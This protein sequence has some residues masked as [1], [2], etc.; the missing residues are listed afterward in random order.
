MKEWR[1]ATLAG[2]GASERGV[3]MKRYG[4]GALLSSLAG[5]LSLVVLLCAPAAPATATGAAAT[6]AHAAPLNPRFVL[7]QTTGLDLLPGGAGHGRGQRPAPHPLVA[8]GTS[9]LPASLGYASSFD[10]RT[11]GKVSPVRNQGA[12]GTCWSF[13][14][15]GSLESSFLPAQP[16]DFAEDHLVLT[17]GFDT[18]AT[19]TEKYNHGGNLWYSTAYLTRWGGPVLESD[20]AYGDGVTPAGL[21]PRAHVQD[22]TLYAARA[23]ATDNDRVKYALTTHGAV[24]VA[25]S[26]QNG[27]SCYNA[28]TRAYYYDGSATTNHAVL[29]V[30]W[31]D[32]YA[33]ANFTTA[34]PGDGAFIV[35]N[36]WGTGWG[37]SGYF[38]V[39]YYD[40]RFNRDDYAAT[41]EG[42]PGG[43]EYDT[44]YQ[45]DP[46]GGVSDFGSG[47]STTF[48]GANRFTAAGDATLSAVGF[49]AEVPN[50]AYEVW[51]GASTS[52]LSQAATGTL[53]Q[54]G[55]HTVT[56]PAGP[57]LRAGDQFVVAV[58]LTT[59][60]LKY[61]L[62]IEYPVS[63]YSSAAQASAGESYYSAGGTT[64][65]DLTSW[66]A[67]ANVCLKAYTS[68][69]TAT[70][71]AS[72]STYAFA[73]DATSGWKTAAQTVAITASGG[74]AGRTIHYST[75]GGATWSTAA[76]SS[77]NVSVTGQGAH[78]F[79]F[80]ASDS[81]ATEPTH[82]AGY[83]NVDSVAPTTTDD[84]VTALLVAPST[85]T[86]TPSDPGPGSGMSGGSSRVE[87]KVDGAA[88]YTSGASVVLGGGTH[89]V[90]YRST[91]KAGN[92]ES[93]DRSFTVTVS[94]PGVPASATG[95]AF[96]ATATSGWK[97]TAQT[98][99]MSAGGGIG[100]GRAICYSADGGLTWTTTAADVVA[101]V[102]ST[103]GSHRFRF[104]ALDSLAA[105]T[106]HDPG[107]VNIDSRRPVTRASSA[108]VRK[109]L[110]VALKY[111]VVD[112]TPGCGRAV[113][114]LQIRRP[115]KVVKTIKLGTKPANVGLSYRF[116]ARIARGT[117]T[118]RVLATDIAG[119][120]AAR[121]GSARLVVK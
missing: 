58:R 12:L 67:E 17:N 82:D 54:M 10:L 81:L 118:V 109:G 32:G 94:A 95:Y 96:A 44:V 92:V 113:V 3:T 25:M 55:F 18:G 108:S 36:S 85:I 80:Y 52:S 31:D 19:A 101:A 68:T 114:K 91:D 69:A 39:S 38:Y 87:Y 112:A 7:W 119:N 21:S 79:Q 47:S 1:P 4:T 90:A 106:V 102:V 9:S 117:Y 24:Y 93:P 78:R 62:A 59:P 33:A 53:P 8:P 63:G 110:N 26:W 121:C 27:A 13:A 57:A 11:Q 107:Y 120:T 48:W 70:L 40:T 100:T 6:A 46:L 64:W 115:G 75:D 103:Q 88:V 2:A 105:E 77:V 34:P 29:V 76:G 15:Y 37:A 116:T 22:V 14:T 49:Y 35:K 65:T 23:S 45:H 71:P 5:V 89:T 84:H 20:D 28:T 73:A 30:G 42:D 60:G 74:G 104:Y 51:V 98:V 99:T 16:F 72:S 50:T 83:V 86:L 97:K 43:A 41:F 61:P 111:R 66:N 56:L